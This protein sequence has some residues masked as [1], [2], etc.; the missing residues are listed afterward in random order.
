MSNVEKAVQVDAAKT[1]A[2]VEDVK[3]ALTTGKSIIKNP[4]TW[5]A[6]ITSVVAAAVAAIA[7]WHP[8]FKEPAA[9]QAALASAS[10]LGGM[11]S[12]IVHF[13][14]RRSATTAVT[15]AKLTK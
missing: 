2:T 15:V 11:A 3:A 9:V 12:Q 1:V 14:T 13:A 7:I 5:V 10:V 8:G 6:N 4:N